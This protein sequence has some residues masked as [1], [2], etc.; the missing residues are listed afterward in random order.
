MNLAQTKSALHVDP[1]SIKWS[2]C[3]R[4]AGLPLLLDRIFSFAQDLPPVLAAG[5]PV[6]VYSG[7][8]DLICNVDGGLKWTTE[9]E[10]PGKASF[11]AAPFKNW[12]VSGQVAGTVKHAAST[13]GDFTFLRI[14]D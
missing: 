8:L 12:T 7:E 1:P 14:A 2:T 6:L 9:M 10:W 3:S 11:N 5:V 4:T 13:A